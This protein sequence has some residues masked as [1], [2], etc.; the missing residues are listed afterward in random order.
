MNKKQEIKQIAEKIQFIVDSCI[1]QKKSDD[2]KWKDAL[3]SS[4]DDLKRDAQH[5]RILQ[6]DCKEK[7]LTINSI[8]LEGYLRG[9]LSCID[10][11]EVSMGYIKEEE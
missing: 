3:L 1:E 11:L 5:T 7:G 8:E 4:L 10:T 6:E 2:S 9:V